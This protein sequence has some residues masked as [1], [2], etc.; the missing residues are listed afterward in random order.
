MKPNLQNHNSTTSG[1]GTRREQMLKV[2]RES[3]ARHKQKSRHSDDIGIGDSVTILSG[4]LENNSAT[5]HD[6]DYI[7]SFAKVACKN[8]SDLLWLPLTMLARSERM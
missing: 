2:L 4:P 1:D 8:A 3:E 5:V 7:N 6:L